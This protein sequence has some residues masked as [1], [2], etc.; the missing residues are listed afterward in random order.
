LK[1]SDKGIKADF[2]A[3]SSAQHDDR[4]HSNW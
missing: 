4:R 2:Q 3:F 1:L